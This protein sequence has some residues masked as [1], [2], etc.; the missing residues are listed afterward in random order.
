MS[1]NYQSDKDGDA[2]PS[3]PKPGE[4][5]TTF[6][7]DPI[8][9]HLLR[10]V[11]TLAMEVSVSRERA[12]TL[13]HLLVEQGVLTKGAA[14]AFEPEGEE[15]IARANERNALVAAILDPIVQ[16]MTK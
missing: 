6:L 3:G 5:H 11:M 7:E 10:A 13:E 16:D 9:D 2:F 1:K 4:R 12:R 14:D 8:S 15:A